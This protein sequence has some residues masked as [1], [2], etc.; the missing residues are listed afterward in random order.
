MVWKYED[1]IL[2]DHCAEDKRDLELS[3]WQ[4]IYLL[5]MNKSFHDRSNIRQTLAEN[6]LLRLS[7]VKK[8]K[9]KILRNDWKNAGMQ[10]VRWCLVWLLIWDDIPRRFFK[11]VEKWA[12][13][14]S[15]ISIITPDSNQN[16]FLQMFLNWIGWLWL[17][18]KQEK[19]ESKC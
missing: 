4:T 18:G 17:T 14:F 7:K 19:Q 15:F 3:C 12:V 8:N 10:N 16:Q 13:A 2:G 9:S 5:I 11:Q 6:F 1:S